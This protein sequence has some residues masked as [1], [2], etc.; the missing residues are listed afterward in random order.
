MIGI[1]DTTMKKNW[2]TMVN[3]AMGNLK[4]KKFELREEATQ[5]K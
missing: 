5:Q 4:V 3:A 2:N 1:R